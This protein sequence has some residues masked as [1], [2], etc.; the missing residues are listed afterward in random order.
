[1]IG[2]APKGMIGQLQCPF[3]GTRFP[4]DVSVQLVEQIREPG[5]ASLPAVGGLTVALLG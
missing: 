5:V 4:V 1:M 2:H 3:I